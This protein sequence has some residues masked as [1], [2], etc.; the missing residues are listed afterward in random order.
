MTGPT[1]RS[2]STI[3][4]MG[5]W[6]GTDQT[7]FTNGLTPAPIKA[8]GVLASVKGK[9]ITVS[10]GHPFRARKRGTLGDLGGDF[11]TQNQYVKQALPGKRWELVY[12][13]VLS[14][15]TVTHSYKGPA[16][17]IS[18]ADARIG[19]SPFPASVESS[20]SL[21]NVRGAT[22]VAKC[23]PTNSVADASVFLG[24]MF[25]EGLPHLIGHT[26]WKDAT[27]SAQRQANNLAG[28][29]ASEFL[30][31]EFGW[32]P[33][34]SDMKKFAY[35]ASHSDT[36]LAQYERDSGRQ[37]RRRFNFPV[38]R[39]EEETRI[40]TDAYPYGPTNFSMSLPPSF[41]GEVWRHREWSRRQWFSGAFTY[42]LP[43]DYGSR[44]AMARHALEAKKLLGLSLTPD[45]VWNL[46]PWS[47]AVDWFTNTGDVIDN[48]TD[49]IVDGLV[50]RYGYIMEHSIVKDTYTLRPSGNYTGKTRVPPLTF[51]TETKQRKRANP[52]G[53]GATFDGLTTRQNAILLAL[54]LTR[55]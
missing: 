27:K 4:L 49:W 41:A 12:T 37:V 8:R 21:L 51:V 7:R 9:Q 40:A 19:L 42:Y 23:K 17:P 1:T 52:F 18:P 26:L 24:E 50:M 43:S 20:S 28:N 33:I 25:R 13:E 22:A 48:V 32:K 35:V 3:A 45:V 34:V 54:G 16:Y 44:N 31:Y 5:T 46:S 14:D 30:N 55:S 53:F 15:R 29:Q 10:S 36:V 2:R 6:S 38:Q 11:Y 47:W 39:G